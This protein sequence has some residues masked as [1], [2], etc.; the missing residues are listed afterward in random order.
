MQEDLLHFV[1]KFQLFDHT[2][3]QTTAGAQITVKKVGYHNHDAG[4][5]FM[6]ARVHIEDTLWAGNVEIHNKASDWFRHGHHHDEAYNNVILHV[7][8]EDDLEP[9]GNNHQLGK[10]PCLVLQNR[11]STEFL[12]RY[13][14]L[15]DNQQWI[16]CN[17]HFP[18]VPELTIN[19]WMNRVLIE[20]LQEKADRLHKSLADNQNDWRETFYQTLARNFGFK[21]NAE[22]FE[23]LS[24]ALPLKILSK[25]KDKRFQLEALLFGQAGMLNHVFADTY[26]RQLQ[27]EYRFLSDK[28]GLIPIGE[29]E[30]NLLR[31]RPANFP[32]IRIAQ[33]AHLI[34]KGEGLF[35]KVLEIE[36]AETIKKLFKVR[37]SEY[38]NNHYQFDRLAK[39]QKPKHLGKKGVENVLINTIVPFLFAY[40]QVNNDE[41]L[42]EKAVAIL[43]S[44]PPEAN[45][46]VQQWQ[47][48]G[49]KN[50]SS[51][52]SQALLYLKKSYCDKKLCLSCGIGTKILTNAEK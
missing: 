44:L 48:L 14:A 41:A 21:V 10:I 3:L 50:E 52:D 2:E 51:A 33:L 43:E 45:S 9:G 1:W 5:D 22:P 32:A 46:I 16:P 11:L 26:P 12:G 25:H 49:A 28:Y 6:N 18:Q 27:E 35:K 7:V 38:W 31:L 24:R 20:R 19:Q 4:P 17:N 13:K 23:R 47:Q 8:F 40:G 29:H 15:K 42:Q 39:T 34:H 36:D 30:W 37:A